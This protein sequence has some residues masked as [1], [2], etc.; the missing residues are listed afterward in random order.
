MKC[1]ICGTVENFHS[2]SAYNPERELMICKT[3]GQILYRVDPT[4][5]E[6][7]REYYRK[8]YRPDPT[9]MNLLT[10]SN[11]LNYLRTFLGDFFKGKEGMICGDVGC[12]TGYFVNYL[13]RI[14]MRAT[15][16][17]YTVTYR[18]FA[19]HFYSVPV[20]EELTPKHKYNFI[21]IYHVLEH[22]I[23]PDVKLKKYVDMLAEGGHML[24]STPQWG[25]ILE[26]ASGTGIVN[27]GMDMEQAFRKRYAKDH[28]NAFTENTIKRLFAQAGLSIVKEDHIQYGQTYLLCKQDATHPAPEFKEEKWED[29]LAMIDKEREALDLYVKRRFDQ[30]VEL[31]QKFPEAWIKLI[32]DV[33]GKSPDKQTELFAKCQAVL[34]DNV[35]VRQAHAMWLYQQQQFMPCLEQLNWI[36]SIKPNVDILMQ[37]GYCYANIGKDKEALITFTRAAEMHPPKWMEAMQWACRAASRM[38]SWDERAMAEVKE[39]LFDGNKDKIKI[40][41]VD[42]VMN[43]PTKEDTNG[44]GE[45]RKGPEVVRAGA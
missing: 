9:T 36:M 10:T 31:C 40:E 43:E 37:M 29:V 24:I 27:E 39:K 1:F 8:E 32:F 12:A 25:N 42:P 16:C 2:L 22:M 38:P 21:S 11:K 35:R 15:G 34:P 23:E 41:P 17:E 30:A 3:C 6:K 26:E 18:R 44:A 4:A 20:T 13:R 28:I 19:E 5:E 33:N 14:G 45:D 7:M